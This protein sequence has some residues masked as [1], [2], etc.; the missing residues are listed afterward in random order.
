MVAKSKPQREARIK[1]L[2]E[3]GQDRAW[4]KEQREVFLDAIASVW[5]ALS[6]DKTPTGEYLKGDRLGN[7]RVQYPPD[8]CS[9][10]SQS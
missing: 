5:D 3:N 2:L 10:R 8:I 6:S 4:Q 1:K 9:R 7:D